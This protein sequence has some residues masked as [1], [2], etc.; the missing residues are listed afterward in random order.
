M[1]YNDVEE[2]R[3]MDLGELDELKGLKTKR[4]GKVSRVREGVK[5]IIEIE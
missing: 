2:K 5:R 3:E 1:I 4:Y